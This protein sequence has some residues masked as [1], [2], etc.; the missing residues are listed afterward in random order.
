MSYPKAV[1]RLR[2]AI[3]HAKNG[4]AAGAMHHIG[5]AMLHL[6]NLNPQNAVAPEPS[7]P[8]MPSMPKPM[9]APP[10]GAPPMAAPMGAPGGMGGGNPAEALRAR[11]M[12]LG[13]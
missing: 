1:S 3:S 8:A 10:G 5:H 6:R 7:M 12:G 2:Q 11:L 13:K 9:M 4:N